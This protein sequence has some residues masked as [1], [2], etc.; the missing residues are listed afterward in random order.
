[1]NRFFSLLFQL[2][3]GVSIISVSTFCMDTNEQRLAFA[4]S[5]IAV[6]WIGEFYGRLQE[7]DKALDIAFDMAIP[8]WHLNLDKKPKEGVRVIVRTIW[9][10]KNPKCYQ[11]A[12]YKKGEWYWPSGKKMTTFQPKQWCYIPRM[13][14]KGMTK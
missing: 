7:Y 2:L 8:E 6:W 5:L 13:K 12:V 3:I 4:I 10:K 14:F 1:M 11:I 9:S